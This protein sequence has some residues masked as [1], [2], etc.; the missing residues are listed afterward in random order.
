MI[1]P[2]FALNNYNINNFP[3]IMTPHGNRNIVYLYIK[4]DGNRRW[5]F[6]CDYNLENGKYAWP[7]FWDEQTP[8][9]K[10]AFFITGCPS[11]GGLFAG[12]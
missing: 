9:K 1:F 6:V 2:Y 7:G 10:E 12:E 4:T 3:G 11:V 5:F 8:E